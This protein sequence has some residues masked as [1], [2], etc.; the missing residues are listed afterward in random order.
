MAYLSL[1]LMT[2]SGRMWGWMMNMMVGS[3]NGLVMRGYI[4]GFKLYSNAI[5]AAR[6]S[7]NFKRS[8]VICSS[9]SWRNGTV[10]G[11][12]KWQLVSIQPFHVEDT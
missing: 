4:Q 11:W 10:S 7:F 8:A 2:T 12:H 9:G 6:R 5:D 1:K 3:H